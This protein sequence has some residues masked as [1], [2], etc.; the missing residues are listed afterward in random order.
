MKQE[1]V[2]IGRITGPRVFSVPE[3]GTRASFTLECLGQCSV[4][5]CIAGDVARGFLASCRCR[6]MRFVNTVHGYNVAFTLP[7]VG[8]T[9]RA[10]AAMRTDSKMRKART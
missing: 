8:S 1:H 3:F 5:C 7:I 2:L 10:H 6:R 9:H 4:A